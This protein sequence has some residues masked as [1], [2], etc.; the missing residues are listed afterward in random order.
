MEIRAYFATPKAT[1][2][3]DFTTPSRAAPQNFEKENHN[4]VIVLCLSGHLFLV[5]FYFASRSS[6]EKFA[7]SKFCGV[8]DVAK[9]EFC[10]AQRHEYILEGSL[11]FVYLFCILLWSN[12][13]RY[14]IIHRID[15]VMAKTSIVYFI[16]Y[17]ISCK[18]METITLYS[19]YVVVSGIIINAYLSN[20]YSNKEWCSREHI[21]YHALLHIFCF[22]GSLYAF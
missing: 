12:P 13:V 2:N 3:F 14:S 20:Y 18:K 17:T 19:Y 10:A 1:Q 21:Y 9:S 4:R 15:G 16:T 22:I 5:S 7:F 6:A 11:L 8:E